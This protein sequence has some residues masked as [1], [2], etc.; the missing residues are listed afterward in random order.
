MKQYN[1]IWPLPGGA[2][3]YLIA[4]R[5]LLEH[6]GATTPTR[7]Q[8][9][10]N[11]RQLFPGTDDEH[12]IRTQLLIPVHLGYME[13]DQGKLSL[14]ADGRALL[15]NLE[16][17]AVYERLAATH[18]GFTEI[19]E[20]LA[21]QKPMGLKDIH[22][23]LQQRVNDGWTHQAQPSYRVNWLRSLGLVTKDG[24]K[25]VLTSL[26]QSACHVVA[27]PVPVAP[28]I[29]T[30]PVVTPV[31][32][33]GEQL[34]A[35]LCEL[36]VASTRPTEFEDVLTEAFGFLGFAARKVGGSG[37]PDVVVHAALGPNSYTVVVDA[38]TTG[39]GSIS[40]SH[41]NLNAL[42]D[43]KKKSKADYVA[44]VA[45]AFSGDNLPKW[46]KEQ[47]VR[48]IDVDTLSQILIR[49]EATPFSLIDLRSLFI[50]GG[51]VDGTSVVDDLMLT[52]DD[53]EEAQTLPS[54]IFG[55]LLEKQA[56]CKARLDE[57]SLFFLLEEEHEVAD[58]RAALDFL[59]SP[60]VAAIAE[61]ATRG[62]STRYGM[63]TFAAKMGRL[64]ALCNG[65]L[66]PFD[67]EMK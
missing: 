20:A 16:P 52:A 36:A 8:M 45:V 54:L 24:G 14:T 41:V 50:G 23:M 35:R 64:G 32:S 28:V 65:R 43:H 1:A 3:N 10:E 2:E 34:A 49:H 39:R 44:V 17:L 6:V 58:I 18:T 29:A 12:V 47:N 15:A 46:S 21:E 13:M 7:E 22:L 27:P 57:H 51:L 42:L 26:G 19:V 56:S 61:D 62:L 63:S 53:I 67:Q 4:L 11:Y 30:P 40:Q 38:K 31:L 25:F 60:C 59:R 33:R 48:L 9:V 55:V 5:R 37:E 66:A